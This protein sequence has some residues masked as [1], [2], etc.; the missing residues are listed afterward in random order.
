MAA[1]KVGNCSCARSIRRSATIISD[2][3]GLRAP[4]RF[5]RAICRIS[6]Q[7]L[8]SESATIEAII[9]G[10]PRRAS[11]AGDDDREQRRRADGHGPGSRHHCP[12]PTNCFSR[13]LPSPVPLTFR[14]EEGGHA[15]L[16]RSCR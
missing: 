13:A 14:E 8:A 10:D 9:P 1:V 11:R 15:C 7:A 4:L 2:R 5:R 16:D 3:A 6:R 12:T